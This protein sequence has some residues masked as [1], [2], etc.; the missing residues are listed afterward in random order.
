MRKTLGIILISL[1][2]LFIIGWTY[3]LWGYISISLV[4]GFI[5]GFIIDWIYYKI[6]KRWKQK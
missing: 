1:F 5:L 4:I 3:T 6:Q 2:I